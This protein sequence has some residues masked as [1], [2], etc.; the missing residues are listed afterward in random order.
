MPLLPAST[1]SEYQ[2]PRWAAWFLMLLGVF[3]FI[4][5]LIH[6]FL[7]DG[8]AGVIGGVDLSTRRQ[9]II[10]V[11]AW[12]GSI[13]IPYG[14]ILFVIGLR[15]RTLVPLGL[16]AVILSRGLMSYDGW[17]GKGALGG[18]HPPEHYGSPVA[19]VLAVI[20]LIA[21]VRAQSRAHAKT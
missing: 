20:V 1:N 2:G 7:P 4:P 21:V 3:E 17:F 6:F 15:Y 11:F 19:V 12:F 9:T 16:M 10:T 5:G 8:G 14:L 18:H 13:Q